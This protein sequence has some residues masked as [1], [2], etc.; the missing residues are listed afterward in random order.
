MDKNKKA[1]EEGPG[2]GR[3]SKLI[4]Y[5]MKKNHKFV[6]FIVDRAKIRETKSREFVMNCKTMQKIAKTAE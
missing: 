2:E 4:R 3:K 6:E 1:Y 5:V